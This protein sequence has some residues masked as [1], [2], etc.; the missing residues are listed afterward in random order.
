MPTYTGTSGND[1]LAGSAG[2]DVIDGLAGQDVMSGGTGNDVYYVDTVFDSVVENP[3]EGV[4]TVHAGVNYQLSANVENLTLIGTAVSGGGNALENVL[5]GNALDNILHGGD[6]RDTLYGGGG[7]DTLFGG[8]DT[9]QDTLD[10]GAG[11]DI[12]Y[13]GRGNDIYYVDSLGDVAVEYAGE[14]AADVI[15]ASISWTLR[16]DGNIESLHLQGTGNLDGAGNSGANAITGTVGH[17]VLSGGAGVDTIRG[18]GGNDTLIGGLGNDNLYGQAGY[19]TFVI[20]NESVGFGP[21]EQ[22]R[23]FDLNMAGG[24]RIDVSAIDANVG[25]AGDQAFTF[26]ASFTG[27]AGQATATYV[28]SQYTLFDFDVN[29]DGISDYQLRAD[30]DHTGTVTDVLTGGEAISDGGWLL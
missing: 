5:T 11:D 14:G 21:P 10:G 16:E 3:G 19:D 30:G 25:T 27:A 4:D 23:I 20:L 28:L 9:W 17:N 7:N 2:D 22:D 24:D 1:I 18:A 6:A 15:R 26:V 13:G 8:S 12:M 29:G